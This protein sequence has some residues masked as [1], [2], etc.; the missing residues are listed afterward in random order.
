MSIRDYVDADGHIYHA[1]VVSPAVP[2]ELDGLVAAFDGLDARPTE[3]PA[4]A[5]LIAA[6]PA[7]GMTPAIIDRVYELAGLRATRFPR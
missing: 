1:P 6:G 2:P 7:G 4:M 3:R 5:G